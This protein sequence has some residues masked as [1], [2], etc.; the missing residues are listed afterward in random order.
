MGQESVRVR[1]ADLV[2]ALSLGVD[3]GFGQPMEHAL[4]QCMIALRLADRLTLPQ[5][6][7][8][9]V[10]Y[11][12]LLIVVG[13]HADAHEQAKWFSD[14][15]AFKS[16][17]YEHD[18][19]SLAGAVSGFGQLGAGLGP[20]HRFRLGLDLIREGRHDL[21][22]MIANHAALAQS[23]TAE[24]GL[25]DSVQQ[26]VGAAYERWDGRGWPGR[27]RGPSIPIAARIAQLSEYVEVAHRLGGVAEA[28]QL[29]VARSGGQ[30]DP[31]LCALVQADGDRLLA[32]LE[33]GTTWRSVID[34]EPSLHLELTADEADSALAG[35][36]R[37]VDL[38]SPYFLGH[39]GAVAELVSAASH[40]LGLPP[41]EQLLVRRAAYVLGLGRLGI[42]NA[43]WDKAGPL[44]SGEW[45]RVRLQPYLTERM[46]HQ[47]E[48]L[49]P[50]GAVAAKVRERMDGSGYPSGLSSAA[51][52]LPARL[53]ATADVYQAM[54]EPRPQRGELSADRAARQ[55]RAQAAA[56]VLDAATVDAVLA[57][58][59]QAVGRR[60][61]RPD[62]LTAR[63]VEVLRL[64]ASGL[65]TK[66]IARRLVI[67]PKTARNHVEHIYAKVGVT[68]RAAA[69]LYAV[70]EGL[71]P[72]EAYPVPNEA[73]AP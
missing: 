59:G 56:G 52:S 63:E 33:G 64:V 45:E 67:S 50:L 73:V 28:R 12:A 69:S 42:S 43:I 3:L 29:V 54:R 35:V 25:A 38:K 72:V 40:R 30:F 20:L 11:T 1:L 66:E 23:L 10:Y 49:A 15:I 65:T 19:R 39:S 37:F 18:A 53:L 57:V 34:A 27:L 58:A 32:D 2:A 6:Q 51:L 71:L 7:R 24:L 62:G 55:L 70:R 31:M 5:D 60:A 21:L 4:R 13:C 26:S 9:A 17:K 61:D 8:R 68:N 16:H 47:S 14:D 41:H 48:W 44:G 46:L 36:G 22:A